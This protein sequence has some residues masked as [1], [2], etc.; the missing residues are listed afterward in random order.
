MGIL[1]TLS[2]KRQQQKI[3]QLERKLE[4]AERVERTAKREVERIAEE[5]CQAKVALIRAR[6][7]LFE[8]EKHYE[9]LSE[10]REALYEMIQEGP[11]PAAFEAQVELDRILRIITEKSDEYAF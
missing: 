2:V 5:I 1:Q 9:V 10:E 7:D 11:S 4:K 8:N 6:V 3:L